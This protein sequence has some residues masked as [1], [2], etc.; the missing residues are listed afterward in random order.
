MSREAIA[1]AIGIGPRTAGRLIA[2][3]GLP[4][5]A[6]LDAITG[7]PVRSGP[8]SRVRYERAY[9]GELIHIDVKKL[10]RIPEGGGWRLHGRGTRPARGRGAGM[11]FVHTAIDDR[12]R[13]AYVEVLGDERGPTCAG[14]LE[15]AAAHFASQGIARIQRVMTDN[16]FNYRL[17][18]DFQLALMGLGARHVLIRPH[19]P[20]T[21]GKAERLNR[22]LLAEWAYARPWLSNKERAAALAGWLE[23]YNRERPHGA[24][25]G[26]PPISRV[27]TTW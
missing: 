4:P 8:M 16:A 11:D 27:S 12:S 19:C 23:H 13:L 5:L 24:L 3:A 21:N 18:R 20:W 6:D 25:G 15:R 22:T 10:G 17:S 9:P 26:L 14:F 7:Q 2:R 1:R